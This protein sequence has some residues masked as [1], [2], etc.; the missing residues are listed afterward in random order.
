MKNLFIKN[1]FVLIA[2]TFVGCKSD[3]YS[4]SNSSELKELTITANN[5]EYKTTINPE[6][7]NINIKLN[8]QQTIPEIITIKNY[9][10][11]EK[12]T[13]SAKKEQEIKLYSDASFNLEVTAEDKKTK[14]QYNV[15]INSVL[16]DLETIVVEIKK[17]KIVA[18]K[19]SDSSFL[20]KL[21]E[22]QTLEDTIILSSLDIYY[23][24][25]SNIKTGD[26]I[27]LDDNNSFK[28][29]ITA[30]EKTIKKT[31]V[32][33]FV[34]YEEIQAEVTPIKS[35]YI[36]Y[37]NKRFEATIDNNTNPK[38]IKFLDIDKTILVSKLEVATF[39]LWSDKTK[40]S[41]GKEEQKSGITKNIFYSRDINYVA[42]NESGKEV[43]Y[44]VKQIKNTGGY[45]PFITR[46]KTDN[47]SG[48]SSDNKTIEL[49]L[50]ED[51]DYDF[52]VDWGDGKKERITSY[53]QAKHTYEQ[54]G[55]YDITI[56]G[57]IKGWS[58]RYTKNKFDRSKLIELKQWGDINIGNK[59]SQF[60][61]TRNLTITAT[62]VP[63]LDGITDLS[64]MFASSKKIETVP[65]MN[66]WDVSKIT[67]MGDMFWEAKNFNQN[68]NTWDVSNVTNMK[69]MFSEAT[70]FDQ[71]IGNWKV[72]NVTNMR[73][74]F[75]KA[76]SFDQDISKWDVSNVTDMRLMFWE[77]TSFDQDISKWNVEKVTDFWGVFID[78]PI[79]NE[80]KPPK[81][82]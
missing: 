68:I 2:L 69:L 62:D 54:I 66:K 59:G 17:N 61:Y 18:E 16:T 34:T 36:E 79:K 53:E 73:T 21:K 52:E 28:I 6:N 13:I 41:V 71:D 29:E 3:S 19:T 58:T 65:N 25:T 51:G 7:N 78:C 1:L 67:N 48:S 5:T 26:Q 72:S 70:S 63:N 22:N 8:Q 81:F 47:T 23:R 14:K 11:S 10:I 77:A 27:K 50:L 76:T 12:A 31:Y 74:M 20:I 43:K 46:W 9:V 44:V 32:V 57:K 4:P 56:T 33:K 49:P 80:H 38:T 15:F 42:V 40:L 60:Y 82:R 64:W 30:Q 39:E 37:D 24:S 55:E 45:N 35:F 75:H